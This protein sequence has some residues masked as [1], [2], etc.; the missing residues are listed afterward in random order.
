M[1]MIPGGTGTA[2]SFPDG[3]TGSQLANVETIS[4]T[5]VLVTSD[6]KTQLLTPSGALRVAQLPATALLG[7]QWVFI[8]GPT[9]AFSL[10]VNSSNGSQ[11][12]LLAPGES[13]SIN[14]GS[15]TP[16]ANTDW[17]AQ[18]PTTVLSNGSVST[19]ALR[20]T[21]SGSDTG[22]YSPSTDAIAFSNA[23]VQSLLVSSAGAVTLGPAG[24]Q[25]H[26]ANG[27]AFNLTS[28]G[29]TATI[30]LTGS[31]YGMLST[32][33]DLYLET[34]SAANQVFFRK[35]GVQTGNIS[36]TG[37]WTIGNES[38]DI[39]QPLVVTS[40][41]NGGMVTILRNA[42]SGTGAYTSLRLMNNLGT[43]IRTIEMNYASSAYVGSI[44]SGGVSG[45][46][47]S[48]G[49]TGAFPMQFMTNNAYVG[50]VSSTG[51]WTLGATSGSGSAGHNFYNSTT[52][53]GN[54]CVLFRKNGISQNT[55]GNIY[56]SFIA[57]GSLSDGAIQVSGSTLQ[58]VDA[59]DARLKENVREANYGLDTVLALRPVIYDWIEEA[60]GQQ[61]IKGFLAQEVQSVLPNSVTVVQSN[62]ETY[63]DILGIGHAEFIPVLVKAIQ[64]LKAE[65]E[66][67]K[68]RIAI[69][70]GAN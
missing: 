47:G 13:V 24:T 53:N 25:T 39:T 7:E 10:Q 23:G 21:G 49:T 38:V 18:V 15:T 26:T 2:A 62:H 63:G 67:S 42:N 51:G 69:L 12:S 52:T 19:P 8:C 41:R 43:G 22:I 70:E 57:S 20:F 60:G 34:A 11:I 46:S 54:E 37:A 61:D 66:E 1:S 5:K 44:V 50:H 31:A 48:I 30:N 58:I 27:Q 3:F 64:E 6:R 16:V 59:S 9:A 14:A 32:N 36:N 55:S 29:A 56:C 33:S 4:A 65:L 28:T 17:I 68:A 45:E 40:S 35:G